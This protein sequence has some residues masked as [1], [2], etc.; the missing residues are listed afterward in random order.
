MTSTHAPGVTTSVTD[1]VAGDHDEHHRAGDATPAGSFDTGSP[2]W[3]RR[4]AVHAL[5]VLLALVGLVV[6][7]DRGASVI[8]DE[9]AV[10][11]QT[12]VISEGDW[13]QPETWRI[14][15]PFA[16]IDPDAVYV[17]LELSD[18][19]GDSYLPYA[20]HPA[21]PVLLMPAWEAFGHRGIMLV[22]ALSAWLAAVAGALIARRIRPGLEVPTLWILGVGSPLIFDAAVIMAHGLAAALMGF[23]VL[24]ASTL[25]DLPQRRAVRGPRA[26]AAVAGMAVLT[27][28][29]VMMRSEGFLASIA[30]AAA[31]GL[32]ALRR[33]TSARAGIRI[34]GS[35]AVASVVVAIAGV[36][37][38]LL[39]GR[40]AA[41]LVGDGDTAPYR[42]QSTGTFIGGRISAFSRSILQPAAPLSMASSSLLMVA[43]LMVILAAVQLRRGAAAR[44]RGEPVEWQPIVLFAAIAA[45]CAVGRAFLEPSLIIGL[46]PAF[47]LLVA[48]LIGLRRTDLRSPLVR[49]CVIT[50][51]LASLAIWGTSYAIGGGAEWG[52]RFYHLLL[53]VIVPVAVVGLDRLLHALPATSLA[54]R[55]VSPRTLVVGCAIVLTAS[56][57]LVWVRY[58]IGTRD[59]TKMILAEGLSA[60][61]ASTPPDDGGLPLIVTDVRGIPRMAWSHIGQVRYLRVPEPELLAPLLERLATT[62]VGTV[63]VVVS[64][65]QPLPDASLQDWEVV[66]R[67]GDPATTYTFVELRRR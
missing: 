45:V 27:V 2:R 18:I 6:V 48:G 49:V 31:L 11:T 43:C 57:G 1:P 40:L 8:T 46:V 29:L 28:L 20:K 41:A 63:N 16:E 17:P 58:S 47:P 4:F 13:T 33:D 52:G 34:R 24:T 3:A 65:Q 42:I 23:L 21:Y 19:A 36:F 59:W 44:D 54:G 5:L 12:A 66:A 62:D 32:G 26:A 60:A 51:V 30:L 39:D 14:H 50:T 55:S 38:Y 67:R 9:G 35:L 10:I 53:P 7:V 25:L 22:S 15:R 56:I 37:A 61:E 64:P